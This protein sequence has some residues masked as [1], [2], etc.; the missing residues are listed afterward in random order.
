MDVVNEKTDELVSV[1]K[2][3]LGLVCELI[4]YARQKET[5]LMASDVK[6]LGE[7]IDRE[8]EAVLALREKEKERETK[9]RT[10]A[11]AVSL[12]DREL[13]LKNI[14]ER[15]AD[16]ACR[17]KLADVEREMSVAMRKLSLRNGRA[18]EHLKQKLDYTAF[19]LNLLQAPRDPSQFYNMQGGKEDPAGNLNLLDYHA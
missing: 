9:A 6:G 1:L 4:D 14:C 8:E 12:T 17:R 7:M 3:E 16:P 13:H 18:R 5:L 15:I 10:L 2:Q 11:A 19:A